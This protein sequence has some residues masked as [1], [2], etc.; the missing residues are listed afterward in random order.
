MLDNE[1]ILT[2]HWHTNRGLVNRSIVFVDN[3]DVPWD[4]LLKE[5]KAPKVNPST[6][7]YWIQ[8]ALLAS[9]DVARFTE[10]SSNASAVVGATFGAEGKVYNKAGQ[11]IHDYKISVHLIDLDKLADKSPESITILMSDTLKTTSM[12]GDL[13]PKVTSPLFVCQ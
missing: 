7:R 3:N 1:K 10:I 6:R 13:R 4:A 5:A 9:L 2:Y 12:L 11:E 8:G